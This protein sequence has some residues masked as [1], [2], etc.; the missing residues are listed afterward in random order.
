[1]VPTQL[2]PL[3]KG[4][5]SRN[6][7]GLLRLIILCTIAG[8]AVASRLFSVIRFESIIHEFDPWFNFRATK[9][10]VQ[11]GFYNFW[12]WFDDRTW[13]PLGRVTGG[14][15]Y[16]GLMVTSGVIYHVLRLL[17]MPVDIRNICVL[18][19]PGFS[20]LTAF[21]SYLIT[22][23]MSTSPSAGLLAAAFMGITPGYISRSVAGSYDNEAIAIFL[24]VFTFYLWIKSVKNGSAMWAALTALFYGY[25]VSAWGGY[26]FITNLLPLHALVLICM[27]RYSARLYV[28]Y[29]TW[30]TLGTL[31]SMQIPF[32]GF[33]PV[34][35]SEHMSA[36]G[37]FGLLQ[38]VAFVEF[39]RQQVPNRQFQTLLR[40]L[41]LLVF[42]V[43]V[44]GLVLLTVSGV[45]A[46][47]SGRFYS[48]WDTGYAKIH[49]PIIASV[50]EHQPTAWPAFFFDLNLMIW[51]F[52]AGVYMCFQHLKDE[53]V[54]VVIYAVLAS[55]FAGVMVRLM[56]TLTPVVCIAAALA[57]SSILDTYLV[58]DKPVEDAQT[59]GHPTGGA[60]GSALSV[61]QDSL[62]SSRAPVKGIY[63]YVSKISIVSCTVT[64]LLLFVL[65]CT[66]VTSNA[67]SSPSVVL[68]SRL[69]DGSQHIIDDYREAYYWLRQ[70]TPDKAKVMSW[71]DYGYQIGGMADRPTL[72]DN[73]TWNN[74]H[75]AT[76]GKAM[77]SRE[78]VSYPILRQHDVDYV[79]VVFGGLLGYSGD[80][81][82]KF[83]WMVRIA[84]GIWPD[85][86]KERDFFTAR[87]EY[88]VDEQATQTMKNSL[89]YKMSYYNFNA[90]FP[91]G[92]AQDR[93]RGARM[94]N[95]GPTLNTLEEAFTSEN[96]I[97]R[98]YKVKDLDNVGR[99]HASA[100]AFD[101]GNKKR[102]TAKR[103]GPRVL[104]TDLD[105]GEIS[106]VAHRGLGHLLGHSIKE[107]YELKESVLF[108][109][110]SVSKE[111]CVAAQPMQPTSH[112]HE[113][114]THPRF[115]IEISLHPS[116]GIFLQMMICIRPP[117]GLRLE[118]LETRATLL[119]FRL[120]SRLSSN[121]NTC[122]FPTNNIMPFPYQTSATPVRTRKPIRERERDREKDRER[123]KDARSTP[124]G[125]SKK[126]REASRS[127]N[128]SPVPS[129]SRPASL[130]TQTNVTLDQLPDPPRSETASP[131]SAKSPTLDLGAGPS[132]S[133]NPL[134]S[135]T[136]F[137]IPA[138]LQPYLETD[139]DED[140][141][142]VKTPQA[143]STAHVKPYFDADLV[144]VPPRPASVQKPSA[145]S[146][147]T[148]TVSA[149][150][151]PS[152]QNP[153]TPSTVTAAKA[154]SPQNPPTS[155]VALSRVSTRSS[156]PTPNLH[157]PRPYHIPISSPTFTPAQPFFGVAPNDP[158]FPHPQQTP[159]YYSMA[160]NPPHPLDM[161][162]MPP[163]NFY[164][165]YGSPPQVQPL[166]FTQVRHPLAREP[167][168]NGSRMSFSSDPFQT[169][170]QMPR[171]STEP[172]TL[173]DHFG[174][175]ALEGDDDA[176]LKRIQNA[177]PDLNHLL[178]LYRQTSGQLGE[179]DVILRQTEA[180]KIRVLEQK[181]ND[182]QR[183]TK[184]LHEAL[185]RS[186]DEN[187][188][189]GEEKDKLRL[190]IGNMTEKHHELQES[191]QGEKKRKEETEEALQALRVEHIQLVSNFRKEK[192][193]ITRDYEE[194]KAKVLKESAAKDQDFLMKEKEYIDHQQRQ[195]QEL[196]ERLKTLSAELS[197]KHAGEITE[198]TQKHAKEKEKSE[199]AWSL[200]N[201]ELED[202]H[203]RLRRDLNDNKDAYK[204]IIDEHVRQRSQEREA[205]TRERAK[206]LSDWGIERAKLGQGSEKL[207]SQHQEETKELQ[208]RWKSTEA[209]LLA[210]IEDLTATSKIDRENFKATAASMKS[211]VAQLNT[212]N[213]KLQKF[214]DALEQVT[215]LRGRGDAFYCEAFDTLQQQISGVAQDFCRECPAEV[216]S[217]VSRSIPPSLPPFLVDT[218]ASA[219]V[220][221][222]YVQSLISSIINRRIFQ[223]F[224]FTYDQFDSLFNE[225]G[226]C[227]RGKST[228]REAVWRQ[229][230]LHAAFSCVS[231]KQRINTFAATVV[232]EVIVAIKPFA[233]RPQREQLTAA[234]RK[235]IKTAAETWRLARIELPRI[236]ASPGSDGNGRQE[237]ECLLPIFPRIERL[238]LPK[239]LRPEAEDDLGCVYT[240][241]QTLF[242]TSP[243]IL[244]RQA[245]LG[246]NVTEPAELLGGEGAARAD[247]G[248]IGLRSQSVASQVRYS[249]RTGSPLSPQRRRTQSRRGGTSHGLDGVSDDAYHQQSGRGRGWLSGSEGGSR[250]GLSKEM[251]TQE[252]NEVQGGGDTAAVSEEASNQVAGSS[253][254][255]SPA[256]SRAESPQLSCQ[257]TADST[258]STGDDEVQDEA[259]AGALPD[260]GDAG[261]NVPGA[262]TGQHD[263]W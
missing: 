40:T 1:M 61:V 88:K 170:G 207:I 41:V 249:S 173:S 101:K 201:R 105:H 48:L 98:I 259:K 63:S 90:L 60:S 58:A 139:D 211:T 135:S 92:Q 26:V 160:Q 47:W 91:A 253:P 20:G 67:Y 84:E 151:A 260:W 15:L 198:L 79:L 9:Y 142:N 181:D 263:G 65:H 138:A 56:L 141:D 27:G 112:L 12:D 247:G 199:L 16:P 25:M 164:P 114:S 240:T 118:S 214:A 125:S 72:V 218:P 156:D 29:S 77:S 230:T 82:N 251:C 107:S 51:L 261:G 163:Q 81:I 42:L 155:P 254:M 110:P 187:K 128:R 204:K 238:P 236:S 165:P 62:R 202:V 257:T 43:S 250:G 190:E 212:E 129:S 217:H 102:K 147:T 6:T 180:E 68:A 55:Y 239:D 124:S 184:D 182:I 53:H 242:S 243:A 203:V 32:V 159:Q 74:T 21:A 213:S 54:F 195:A 132:R 23:E 174:A 262:F 209:R 133:S 208:E 245:E 2:E 17:S 220:R 131:P 150:K 3:L 178:T 50:S 216:P 232:D 161:Q 258:S 57:L 5:T 108:G 103:R 223:P 158:Y 36:L 4:E 154:P 14:T 256:H 145:P 215:D 233:S 113:R 64:Y 244:A 80:D 73:N 115:H 19:A 109:L 234:V 140:F 130:Y 196:E 126:H 46:P 49:I 200:R 24:L 18:L 224:L 194:W 11:H 146:P 44:G 33:L 149:A 171:A 7:R 205:W 152:P 229:R 136:H 206:M 248:S 69:P 172:A 104:R 111:D 96:W 99:D 186:T 143:S 30:F 177:I 93:V 95:E 127:S 252:Q 231:S 162:A 222:V 192:A 167:S 157:H 116:H 106:D 66:W 228:K 197:Q 22:S 144:Q 34:R 8:A 52:P 59:N 193:T 37:V 94:P 226:E 123:D 219:L 70:N 31:A 97:I 117:L 89:M 153:P 166:P 179:R 185:Q 221:I 176:V 71:W 148:S 235:V 13:H 76:V 10:L 38:L 168:S 87:G 227:L 255:Q 121:L 78:E 85:E 175:G 122:L 75:I 169:M 45:I 225:W 100:V 86:V 246:E 28:S 134:L 35:S 83:L 137:A 189:Q 183:L 119:N 39:I 188:K 191:L 237:G 120:F 241:G 210:E